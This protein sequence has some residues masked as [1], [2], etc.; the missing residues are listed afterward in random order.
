VES[1]GPG[2]FEVKLDGQRRRVVSVDLAKYEV[3]PQPGAPAKAAA[4][5][6]IA[7]ARPMLL[8][9]GGRTFI[10]AVDTASFK[11]LDIKLA[12]DAADR[13]TRGLLADDTVGVYVLPHGPY[14]PPTNNL[15]SVRQALRGVVGRKV[16]TGQFEM[17]VEQMIDI[18]AATASQSSI[19]ARRTVG[20]MM[21]GS[22]VPAATEDLGA[23]E[24]PLEC[25]GSV[26]MCTESAI[27]EAQA[28]ATALEEEVQQGLAA[29]DSLLRQ[30]QTSQIRKTVLLL[31]SGMPVSDRANGRPSLA[32]EVKLLGEQATYA[33]A[34]IHTLFFDPNAL[35]EF[36][37]DSRPHRKSTGRSRVIYTRALA[38]FT[39]PS[40]GTLIE[41]SGTGEAAVD[42]LL[43][44]ISAYYVLGVE[45]DDR[46]RD[47]RPHRLEVKAGARNVQVKSRQLVLVPRKTS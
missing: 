26:Q 2:H 21:T 5:A 45:P 36:V 19:S 17:T 30:L 43:G 4:P 37:A 46:D 10:V 44:Q 15:A 29:L 34:T 8:P 47:G 12:L 25:A 1:L 35:N 28:M 18:T 23:T 27:A 3:S 31:S 14:L 41:I 7:D 20:N 39:E 40:G 6:V 32:R 11:N 42:R 13:F 22:V 38:E 16:D 33:N 24:A 9:G